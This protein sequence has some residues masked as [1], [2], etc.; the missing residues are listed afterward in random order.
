MACLVSGLSNYIKTVNRYGR[1][2][3][4]VQTGWGTQVV[5]SLL[6]PFSRRFLILGQGLHRS[7]QR[8]HCGLCIVLVAGSEEG[9]R[10]EGNCLTNL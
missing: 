2:Q 10:C 8:Y 3:A 4:V 7:S 6:I 1:R 5:S 9:H